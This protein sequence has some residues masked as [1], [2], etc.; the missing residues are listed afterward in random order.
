MPPDELPAH[1]VVRAA[2][3]SLSPALEEFAE[4]HS[5]RIERYPRGFSMWAFLFQHPRGGAASLQLNILLKPESG[6]LLGSLLTHWWLD[7]EPGER[8]LASEFPTVGLPSLRPPDVRYAL[9]RAFD[10]VIGT[11]ESVLTREVWVRRGVPMP[12]LP[13]PT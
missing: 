5:L 4:R 2:F 6:R 12:D 10:Q 11:E 7:I 1:P 3:D 8:R 9:E 13:F